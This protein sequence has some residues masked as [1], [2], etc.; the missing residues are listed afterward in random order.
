MMKKLTFLLLFYSLLA[1]PFHAHA[2]IKFGVKG[3]LNINNLMQE[4]ETYYAVQHSIK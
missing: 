4:E 1:C 3:G 2:G